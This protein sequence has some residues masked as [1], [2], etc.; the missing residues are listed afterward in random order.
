MKKLILIVLFCVPSFVFGQTA[1][2]VKGENINEKDLQYIMVETGAN[3][4][5]GLVLYDEDGPIRGTSGRITDQDK[6][7]I[8]F[9]NPAA[10]IDYVSKRGW[11]YVESLTKTSFLFKR[12]EWHILR[13]LYAAGLCPFPDHF[14]ELENMY[15]VAEGLFQNTQSTLFD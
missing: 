3:P 1:L 7:A 14:P 8:K 11:E 2:Y 13:I 12:K 15:N 10:L 4:Q 9:A 5:N 6:K